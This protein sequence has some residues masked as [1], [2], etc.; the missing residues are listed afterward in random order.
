MEK[1]VPL[2]TSNSEV[3]AVSY[4]VKGFLEPHLGIYSSLEEL[5]NGVSQDGNV[6]PAGR[7]LRNGGRG[8]GMGFWDRKV[9]FERSNCN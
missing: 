4:R 5:G 3:G 8:I 7:I 1:V 9:N 2:V 6:K